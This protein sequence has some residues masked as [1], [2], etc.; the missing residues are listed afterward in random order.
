MNRALLITALLALS[1][2]GPSQA[3][4]S[5]PLPQGPTYYQDV[6]P[7]LA[8]NCNGCH[9][10]GGIAPFALTTP[11]NAVAYSSAIVTA[12]K[13]KIMPPWPPGADS[14][15]YAHD[16]RLSDDQLAMLETWAAAGA[17]LGDEKHPA[18]LPAPDV[19]QLT[20]V[21]V[22]KDIGV[23]YVPD[24]N[25]R[26]DYRCFL[27][28]LDAV[29]RKM[30]TAYEVVP[31]NRRTVHH[32]IGYL[33]SG[34]DKQ[35]L[36]DADNASPDRPGWQCFGGPSPEGVNVDPI[37]VLG[38]WVP[39]QSAVKFQPG[40][41]KQIDPGNVVVVQVHY[42]LAGGHDSDRTKLRLTYAQ[43]AAESTLQALYTVP[44][45]KSDLQ[46]P[47]NGA[48]VVQERWRTMSEWTGGIFFPDN[49]AWITSVAGHMHRLG[50]SISLR[51]VNETGT[52]MLLDIP[53]WDFHWQGTYQLMEPVQIRPTDTM[54]IRCTYD[55]TAA[56][57]AAQ[58]FVTPMRD[59]TWG[60]G[61]EDE[62]CL[63]YGEVVDNN[64][65]P[66]RLK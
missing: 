54:I 44:F 19:V 64:P 50:T 36:I 31:G 16:R 15:A 8:K 59:V 35:A 21:S 1:A 17:P 4:K 11:D 29:E 6:A 5:D 62:M 66:L 28:D 20:T 43:K 47:A 42:N 65:G 13:S 41:A 52:H 48:G 33:F 34:A 40:T 27:V 58:N 57:R 49:E 24:T 18:E 30:V 39:G 9:V 63:A 3:V 22:E 55:N 23:D 61:T 60:E 53:A 51:L 25:L 37:G 32:V 7:L 12:T 26:D 38:G 56:V 46:I 2:C 14:P 10:E 45:W